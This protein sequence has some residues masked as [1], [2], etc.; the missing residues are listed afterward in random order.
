MFAVLLLESMR[1]T[2]WTMAGLALLGLAFTTMLWFGRREPKLVLTRNR[3]LRRF[4][5]TPM[6]DWFVLFVQ[7]KELSTYH[8]YYDIALGD[9]IAGEAY[10]LL[11]QQY[12]DVFLYA[13]DQ[14]VLVVPFRYRTVINQKLRIEEQERTARQVNKLLTSHA[15]QPSV[16]GVSYRISCTI[17]SGSTGLRGDYATIDEL[18]RL[19][20]FTLLR[21]MEQH[22]DILVATE[23]IRR[24][25]EDVDTFH[26]ELERG[27][28][29]DEIVPYYLPVID[30]ATMSLIG[31]EVL[32]RWEQGEYRIIEANRFKQVAEEKNLFDR[33]DRVILTKALRDFAAWRLDGL[34]K[35]DFVLTFNLSRN[36]LERLHVHE[37]V[38]LVKYNNLAPGTIEF[39]ISDQDVTHPH[40]SR[41]LKQLRDTGFRVSLDV[42]H[43][44]T[45][46]LG[47]LANV[48]IHT[49]K[50][51]RSTLPLD[52]ETG[53]QA[54][55]YRTV[56]RLSRV[57]SER[58]MAKGVEHKSQLEWIRT[59]G[60]DSF[61]GYYITPP[62]NNLRIRGFLNKYL[63][64][65]LQ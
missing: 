56:T 24:I 58:L 62:L 21:A 30:V 34:V 20:H 60:I 40:V 65:P 14:I 7:L 16:Q 46:L 5:R 28:E 61:Q 1:Q 25:K 63:N 31:C 49:I 22:K 17:G 52:E 18:V 35:D 45:I 12:K 64:L 47:A 11:Q 23:E 41:V 39:D 38:G 6:E 48:P 15:Y 55:M 3:I 42:F 2:Q 59:L 50:L 53:N 13:P 27:L 26:T 54:T 32:L 10:R 33:L 43:T 37:L 19:S 51:D 29:L 44:D 9:R 57:F 8:Q 4:A 36:T